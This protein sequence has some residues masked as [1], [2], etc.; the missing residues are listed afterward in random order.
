MSKLTKQLEL[1]IIR[2][3][4]NGELIRSRSNRIAADRSNKK[5]RCG[6]PYLI[7]N[8]QQNVVQ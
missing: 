5:A 1:D 8:K 6:C 4:V 7:A 3:A 2:E